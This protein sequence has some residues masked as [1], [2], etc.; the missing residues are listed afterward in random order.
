MLSSLVP[1]GQHLWRK[2][3]A[4]DLVEARQ[5]VITPDVLCQLNWQLL[6]KLAAGWGTTEPCA[7]VFKQR[8]SLLP[9]ELPDKCIPTLSMH[10]GW[11][12]SWAW[13]V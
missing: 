11:V 4:A 7:V 3:Y 12:P 6:F 1:S 5:E 9:D 13:I 2:R 8:C 10:R